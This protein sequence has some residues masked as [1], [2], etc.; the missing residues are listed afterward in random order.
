M[1]VLTGLGAGEGLDGAGE[2]L[3]GSG[4]GLAGVGEG[5]GGAGEGLA[6][7]GEG[8]DGTG[9]G[10]RHTQAPA[11]ADQNVALVASVSSDTAYIQN[12]VDTLQVLTAYSSPRELHA[13]CA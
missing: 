13:V 4:E 10:C 9:D 5:L 8:L 3:E 2:G 1:Q 7:A 6:G 11:K 12:Q